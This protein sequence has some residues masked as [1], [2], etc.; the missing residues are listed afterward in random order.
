MVKLNSRGAKIAWCGIMLMLAHQCLVVH[1]PHSVAIKVNDTRLGL[2]QAILAGLSKDL[3]MDNLQEMIAH[4]SLTCSNNST[5]LWN[6]LSSAYLY[7]R[8]GWVQ[9][10]WFWELPEFPPAL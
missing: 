3:C 10:W 4:N 7:L 8:G 2:Q 5:N 1:F 6:N 9:V